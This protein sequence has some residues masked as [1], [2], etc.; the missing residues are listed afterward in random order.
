MAVYARP[1]AGHWRIAR[2]ETAPTWRC[3]G[4]HSIAVALPARLRRTRNA[5]S[6][7]SVILGTLCPKKTNK[8]KTKACLAP[9][10]NG[11]AF[12]PCYLAWKNILYPLHIYS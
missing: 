3:F 11:S 5:K 7:C 1:A 10:A 4:C 8:Q 12:L 2:D 6:F 9:N